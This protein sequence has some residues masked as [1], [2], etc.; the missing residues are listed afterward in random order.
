VKTV[1]LVEDDRALAEQLRGHLEGLGH[2]V[3]GWSV[4]H[5]IDPDMPPPVDLVVLDL[6]LP[7]RSG[8]QVL[9]ELRACSDVPVLVLS[10]LDGSQDKVRALRLGAD[11]YLSKPFW[12]EEFLERVKAR[13][14]RPVLSRQHRVVLGALAVDLER[15]QVWI[16]EEE[17][18]LTPVEFRL[19][20]AL[21][22]RPGAAVT[23]RWM[24][25]NALDP[26]REGTQRSLDAHISRLRGKLGE[27]VIE[28]VW[29]VGYRLGGEQIA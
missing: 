7:E 12:P 4:G 29:G 19:L 2:E 11:D 1:L 9:E 24:V 5:R 6:M 17:V 26:D 22:R 14:R 23:R 13:L 16:D 8:F 3:I 25:A 27:G 15:R 20:A 18:H 28:T 21:V 10:A